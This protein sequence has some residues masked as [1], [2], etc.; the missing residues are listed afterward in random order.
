MNRVM[1]LGELMTKREVVSDLPLLPFGGI[2]RHQGVMRNEEFHPCKLDV[3][4]K[5]GCYESDCPDLAE[6][7]N[8]YDKLC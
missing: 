6:C 5:T 2:P 8:L 4:S 3:C 1:F 7:T